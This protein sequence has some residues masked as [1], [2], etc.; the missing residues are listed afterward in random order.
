MNQAHY[1][2]Y[3]FRLDGLVW[4]TPLGATYQ[5]TTLG[6]MLPQWVVLDLRQIAIDNRILG[7]K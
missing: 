7:P 5:Q 4:A 2:R 1:Q 6:M 3:L